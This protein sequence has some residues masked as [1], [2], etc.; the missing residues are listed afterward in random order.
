MI[1]KNTYEVLK[2]KYGKFS[3]WAVWDRAGA[4]P[5]SNTGSMNWVDDPRLLRILNTG[6]VFVG[7]NASNTH[8]NQ[9]GEFET[10]WKN[11]HSDY[12]YQKDFKLRFALQ[13]TRYWGSYLTDVIK[14]HVEVE[15]GK[16]AK[17]LKEHPEVAEENTS[18]L[19]E[20][21]SCLGK[22]PVLVAIG[23]KTDEI[24]R[25]YLGD[26]YPVVPIPHYAAPMGK[27]T[28]RERVLTALEEHVRQ[29][30]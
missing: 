6:F 23:A 18:A 5:A 10:A 26:K 25:E 22:R 8:G 3:S 2:E 14:G 24:L 19:E 1:T 13:D 15:S 7:L 27:E 9:D 12:R 30:L 11:F 16:V 29:S 17:Y 20:E 4:T 28:Y 21:L